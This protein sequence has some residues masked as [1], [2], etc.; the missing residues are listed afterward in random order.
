MKGGNSMNNFSQDNKAMYNT[1]CS[2]WEFYKP[3]LGYNKAMIELGRKSLVRNEYSLE[4]PKKQKSKV[5]RIS[6]FY[7]FWSKCKSI[8][9]RVKYSKKFRNCKLLNNTRTMSSIES[10]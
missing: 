10:K 6:N 4:A 3:P 5:V 9:S 2:G 1:L 8:F 7:L